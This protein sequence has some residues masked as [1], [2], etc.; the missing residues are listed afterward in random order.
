MSANRRSLRITL[1]DNGHW[2]VSAVDTHFMDD[3][4]QQRTLAYV[5]LVPT[6]GVRGVAE[7][8]VLEHIDAQMERQRQ[9]QMNGAERE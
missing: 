9:A 3:G 1:I 2:E 7:D 8:L 6:A 4:R 5:Q